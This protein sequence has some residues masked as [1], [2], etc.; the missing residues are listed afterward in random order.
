MNVD[1]VVERATATLVAIIWRIA[2]A[3]VLWL[4]GRAS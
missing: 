3:I 4:V 2:G 1:T